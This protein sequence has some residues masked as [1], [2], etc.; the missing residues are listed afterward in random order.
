MRNGQATTRHLLLFAI[1]CFGL[2]Q[3]A[4]SA[5]AQEEL[6]QKKGLVRK[7]TKAGDVWVLAQY[8]AQVRGVLDN[9]DKALADLQKHDAEAAP[10]WEGYH[11]R[12]AQH[13]KEVKQLELDQ[14]VIAYRGFGIPAD[15]DAF[16]KKIPEFQKKVAE[17]VQPLQGQAGQWNHKRSGPLNAFVGAFVQA[18][19]LLTQLRDAYLGLKKDPEVISAIEKVGGRLGPGRDFTQLRSRVDKAAK[20]VQKLNVQLKEIKFAKSLFS[21]ELDNPVV[22]NIDPKTE[23][24]K[25]LEARNFEKRDGIWILRDEDL[26]AKLKERA[27]LYDEKVKEV[28]LSMKKLRR[29]KDLEKMKAKQQAFKRKLDKKQDEIKAKVDKQGGATGG[30]FAAIRDWQKEKRKEVAFER[31]IA[32]EEAKLNDAE[33]RYAIALDERFLFLE[34]AVEQ[35]I[36]IA[37]RYGELAEDE[38]IIVATETL[39]EELGPAESFEKGYGRLKRMHRSA[40]K[41]RK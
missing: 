28:K 21:S 32:D 17:Q 35:A 8:E 29:R 7:Q 18:D 38:D 15:V 31:R 26:L 16:N 37:D 20:D 6:L 11:K 25:Y 41:K 2:M 40:Q 34:R 24:A 39:G 30:D 12:M 4:G 5:G 1:V 19:S 14:A 36:I 9:Q 13:A 3:V 27:D 33:D 23:P 10:F 22:S